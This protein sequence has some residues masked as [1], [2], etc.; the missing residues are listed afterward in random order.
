MT[1][2]QRLEFLLRAMSGTCRIDQVHKVIYLPFDIQLS[3]V[4]AHD[5]SELKAE[6]KFRVQYEIPC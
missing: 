5:I 6:F 4:N 1:R 2:V 3:P